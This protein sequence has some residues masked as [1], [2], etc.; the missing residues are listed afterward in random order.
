MFCCPLSLHF[1]NDSIHGKRFHA[2]FVRNSISKCF[3]HIY[4]QTGVRC[5]IDPHPPYVFIAF[6]TVHT[7]TPRIRC[8][9]D[10]PSMYGRSSSLSFSKNGRDIL[11]FS[12]F[13]LGQQFVKQNCPTTRLSVPAEFKIFSPLL[14]VCSSQIVDMR[15]WK[16]L[17]LA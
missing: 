11:K 12:F 6:P 13:L 17:Y 9:V 8:E 1:S 3:A 7:N 16:K 4:F 10:F 14:A 2:L 5:P 15:S